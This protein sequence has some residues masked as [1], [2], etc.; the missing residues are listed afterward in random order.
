MPN[1]DIKLNFL[2]VCDYASLSGGK[3]NILG[4]FESISPKDVP[5][6]HPQMY[7]VTNVSIKKSGSYKQF[8]K[9][10]RDGDGQEIIKPFEFGMSISELKTLGEAKIGVVAQLNNTKFEVFGSYIIQIFV[11]LE[12]IGE[13]K[14]NIAKRN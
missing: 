8:I 13:I 11:D 6:I 2:H 12:K 9:V 4:I 5:Y 14:I 10:I 3:L 7:V 1:E